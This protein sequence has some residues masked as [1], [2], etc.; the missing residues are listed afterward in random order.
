MAHKMPFPLVKPS[1]KRAKDK[2][3]ITTG[4]KKSIKENIDHTEIIS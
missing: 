4:L 3:W 2:P 1:S